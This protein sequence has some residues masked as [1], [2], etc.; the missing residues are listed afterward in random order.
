ME[1]RI[2]AILQWIKTGVAYLTLVFLPLVDVATDVYS[3]VDLGIKAKSELNDIY[4]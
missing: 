4:Y 2:P 3:T 1:E